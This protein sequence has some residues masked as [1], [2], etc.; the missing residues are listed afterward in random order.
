MINKT[1]FIH[2]EAVVIGNVTLGQRASVW[3]TAV[4]RGDSDRIEVGDESNVQDGAVLH[5]DDGV[6]CIVGK[7]VTIGHRAIVHGA[8]VED[9]CLIGMGSIVL[10]HAVI[11]AG[12]LVAAGALVTEGMQVPPGSLVVGI[13]AKVLREVDDQTRERIQ[14]GTAA[15]VEMAERH[16]KGEFAR[17]T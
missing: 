10:N 3:P 12:S 2:P 7:R 13:P 17:S 16:R 11:G 9:D 14:R 15:Y 8:T 5:A 1:A 6:P 4:L